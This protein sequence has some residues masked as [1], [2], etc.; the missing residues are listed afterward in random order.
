MSAKCT[1]HN[2]VINIGW[3]T[4]R[5][6]SSLSSITPPDSQQVLAIPCYKNVTVKKI[7]LFFCIFFS[8]LS[9]R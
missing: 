4:F 9:E 3:G 1:I 6:C 7:H 5:S 8:Y 2:G